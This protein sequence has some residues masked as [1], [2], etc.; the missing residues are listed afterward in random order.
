MSL[1]RRDR[2]TEQALRRFDALPSGFSAFLHA[3]RRRGRGVPVSL[4][5][6]SRRPCLVRDRQRATEQSGHHL[7]Q[8]AQGAHGASWSTP[9]PHSHD[10]RTG[11]ST[12][13][14]TIKRTVCDPTEQIVWRMTF[15]HRRELQWGTSRES[16]DFIGEYS[17]V[18]R[19]IAQGVPA[20]P[21]SP[22]LSSTVDIGPLYRPRRLWTC[23]GVPTAFMLI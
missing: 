22:C 20:F 17:R 7:Q 19:R 9:L 18:L 6:D 1:L 13:T 10:S 3:Q 8:P 14:A 5:L 2:L 12:P 4:S 16:G 15:C 23:S 11:D 21:Q